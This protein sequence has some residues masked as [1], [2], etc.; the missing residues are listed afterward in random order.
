VHLLNI[1]LLC[2]DPPPARGPVPLPTPSS[3]LP[4]QSAAQ[5][6]DQVVAAFDFGGAEPGDLPFRRGDVIDVLRRTGSREDW[7]HGQ[8]RGR[9]GDFPANYTEDV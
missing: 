3:N 4:D 6:S 9:T 8:C 5:G 7:W 2:S 1:L